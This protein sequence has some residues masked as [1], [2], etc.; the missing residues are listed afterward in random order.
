MF[1]SKAKVKSLERSLKELKSSLDA[2]VKCEVC[3]CY[4][5]KYSANVGKAEIKTR[6]YNPYDIYNIWSLAQPEY[7]Y[8]PYYCKIHIP[9]DQKKRK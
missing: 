8:H 9:K 5:D 4:L 2:L 1:I 3:G 6:S 7:I